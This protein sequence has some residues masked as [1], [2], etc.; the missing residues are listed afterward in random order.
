[1]SRRE[2]YASA[3]M[4]IQR[5]DMPRSMRM[6][7]EEKKNIPPEPHFLSLRG[8]AWMVPKRMTY[9]MAVCNR[10]GNLYGHAKWC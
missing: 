6:G 10:F 2:M 8:R 1:M 5:G 9:A 3:N 7:I 4:K